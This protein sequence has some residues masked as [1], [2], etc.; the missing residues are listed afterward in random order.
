MLT[1]G[2]ILSFLTQVISKLLP[3]AKTSFVA[4]R[5]LR[6][7]RRPHFQFFRSLWSLTPRELADRSSAEI[8]KINIAS[9]KYFEHKENREFWL[10]RPFSHPES[11]GRHLERFGLLLSTLGIRPGDRV[12]DFGCGTGW[13]SIMMTRM[14]AEVTAMDIAPAALDIGRESALLEL[15]ESSR[16]RLTFRRYGGDKIDI[17]DGEYDFVV[18]YD[19]FHHFPNPMELLNEFHR[20]LSPQG[21]FGF[22]EP[23]I[24]HATTEESSNEA[25][26]GIL[27]EDL[28]LEQFFQTAKAAGF[29]NLELAIP[30][31][32][33]EILTLSMGRMRSF[34]RGLSWLVPANFIR[35]SVLT[36]PIGV[37]RKGPYA[38]TS[39]NPR[40]QLAE[41]VPEA[42]VISTRASL[43]VSIKVT[44]KNLT[45]TVWL[46][47]GSRGRGEVR[48][49]AHL[50]DSVGDMIDADFGRAALPTAMSLG[51]K[52]IVELTVGAPKQPGNYILRLD[53]VNEGICWFAQQGS[54]VV[55]VKW[56]VDLL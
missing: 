18:V 23:G 24:G 45:S 39:M 15:N 25:A 42:E 16:Q 21:R 38:V 17:K 7:F 50:L 5:S 40:S 47:K 52:A 9:E 19:A 54:S 33:P 20:I 22:A 26:Y 32:E 37:F 2:S 13:T 56:K 12:L 1:L 29:Y 34:L 43:P 41:I 35:K 10:N 4:W 3:G 36:G 49:G 14:G 46:T 30:P 53:M 44:V 8:A 27:E 51:D 55:D 48:L 11:V 28:D 6:Q 31:L